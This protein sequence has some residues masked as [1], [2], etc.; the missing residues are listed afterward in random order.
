[1]DKAAQI[2]NALERLNAKQAAALAHTVELQ[3]ASGSEALPT[4]AILEALR[5]RLREE[6]PPR[7]PDLRRLVVTGFEEFLADRADD[8][9]IDGLIPRTVIAPWWN[10]VRR[11]APTGVEAMAARLK[12]A[13]AIDPVAGPA[14]LQA[15]LHQEAAQW[16]ARVTAELAKPKPDAEV[17]KL[18]RGAFADDAKVIAE[19]LTIAKPLSGAIR[20]MTRVLGHLNLIEG[21]RITELA[22]DAITSL[23]QNYVAL[24]ESHGMSARFLAL[25]VLNRLAQPNQILR[26]GRALSW[27]ANDS[28]VSNTEFGCV[29]ARLIAE[30]QLASRDIAAQVARRNSL[31]APDELSQRLARYFVECE[32]LLAE[33]GLRRDSQWG[34]AILKSR[35][36]AADAIDGSVLARY[37]QTALAVMPQIQRG[38][39]DPAVTPARETITTALAVVNLLQLLLQ[40]GQRHGFGQAARET[41]EE[42]GAEIEARAADLIGGLHETPAHVAT[43]EAQI[44]AAA[45]L[46][47][48]LFDDGRGQLMRRRFA[49][50]MRA[51]A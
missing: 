24:S 34:E 9:R 8:P 27:K 4:N 16:A 40:R 1:M 22:P 48:V 10:A 25:A 11:L 37:T 18:L 39:A 21:R 26:L 2:G 41:I 42:L 44:E 20:A 50:A 6:R 3:R 13:I 38:Q 5:P 31:P 23:K 30:L 45:K 33:M 12:A 51:S 46:C 49:N 35:A 19:V 43:I 36:I 17:K 32:S 29:G 28:L 14:G 15:D 47:D 7:V